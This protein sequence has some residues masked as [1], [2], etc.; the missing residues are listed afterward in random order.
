M[1]FK[2]IKR[3]HRTATRKQQ[4]KLNNKQGRKKKCQKY[5]CLLFMAVKEGMNERTKTTSAMAV[6]EQQQKQKQHNNF[7]GLEYTEKHTHIKKTVKSKTRSLRH[8]YLT[9]HVVA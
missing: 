5:N 3:T 2:A 1:K 7:K 4:S 8:L 9:S 6:T